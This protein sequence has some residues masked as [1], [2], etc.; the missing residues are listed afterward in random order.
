MKKIFFA[1]FVVVFAV[2]LG[3]SGRIV[4]SDELDDITK[5]IN[6]LTTALN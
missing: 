4:F 5:Q 1:I 2:F 6:D 3:F